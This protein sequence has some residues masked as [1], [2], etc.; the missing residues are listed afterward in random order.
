MVDPVLSGS[1]A[2]LP[3]GEAI[4]GSGK[5]GKTTAPSRGAEKSTLGEVIVAGS[6]GPP[7]EK[8]TFADPIKIR[9]GGWFELQS[10]PPASEISFS[11]S[12]VSP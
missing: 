11:V 6:R 9:R 7:P 5:I 3:G 12:G 4:V 8:S 2:C 1:E 10:V